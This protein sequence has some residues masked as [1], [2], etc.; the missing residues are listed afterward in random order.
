LPGKILTPA[1]VPILQRN[2]YAY[3][4]TRLFNKVVDWNGASPSHAMH[5]PNSNWILVTKIDLHTIVC[6]LLND[7][8][9]H[10][11]ATII[12]LALALK[13]PIRKDSQ[14]RPFQ[15]TRT[16]FVLCVVQTTAMVL[17]TSSYMN[18]V[19][20]SLSITSNR[21]D[22]LSTLSYL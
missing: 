12:K 11:Q 3:I 16:S 19:D 8:Q 9:L 18:N 1:F 4:S 14:S 6:K 22:M 20:D 15:T 5:Y 21:P 17:V 7:S 13:S 10:M 2:K